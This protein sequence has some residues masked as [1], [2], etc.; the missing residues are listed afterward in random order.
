MNCTIT[1][2]SPKPITLWLK[3]ETSLDKGDITLFLRE[4][5]HEDA[6]KYTCKAENDGGVVKASIYV[7]V[8][9]KSLPVYLKMFLS[10]NNYF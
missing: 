9:S 4:V 5:T 2:G 10:E 1:E 6:G 7:T 3:N 8:D